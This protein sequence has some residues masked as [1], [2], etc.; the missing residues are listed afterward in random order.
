[1]L[2]NLREIHA[3]QTIVDCGSLGKAAEVLHVTQPALSRIVKRLEAQ[4]G[5]PLFERHQRG[6]TLTDYGAQ[7]A[8]H[9]RLL[10]NESARAVQAIEALRGMG[11]GRV[12]VGAVA[13]ALESFVPATVERLLQKWPGLQASVEEGLTEDLLAQLAR[14]E[15]DLALTFDVPTAPG[16]ERISEGAWQEGCYVVLGATHPLCG[17]TDLRLADLA[18]QR[19][20]LVPRGL[21]PREDWQ[22]LFAE[23]QLPVPA[24]SVE[25]KSINLLRRLV[26]GGGYLGWMPRALFEPPAPNPGQAIRIL[27]LRDV[28]TTRRYAL[29]RRQESHLSPA[30]GALVEELLAGVRGVVGI[31]GGVG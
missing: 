11:R 21:Q 7:L 6:A 16:L 28:Q 27:P 15:I 9:A 19:W 24:A 12:R 14:G 8:P 10:L 20:A 25:S 13:S 5:V 18:E 2:L 3:F 1:M 17:R 30:T 23:R 26:A 29:Y 31:R 22:Q 4:L